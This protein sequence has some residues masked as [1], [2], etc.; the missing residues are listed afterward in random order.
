[1]WRF[2]FHF[3]LTTFLVIFQAA[4]SSVTGLSRI[5]IYKQPTAQLSRAATNKL[6]KNPSARVYNHHVYGQLVLRHP[7]LP[8]PIPQKCQN[9]LPRPRQ[10]RQNHPSPHAQGKPRPS[11]RPHTPPQHGRTHRRPTQAQN[12]RSR[13]ARNRPSAVARLLHHRGRRGI[14]R[15]CH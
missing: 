9:P 13:G 12:I 5:A 8:R 10:R 7:R 4:V 2:S 15:R 1:M 3:S 6:P 11:T 14:P